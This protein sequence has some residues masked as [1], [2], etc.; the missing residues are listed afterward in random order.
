MKFLFVL[1]AGV[2]KS[3]ATTAI[4]LAKEA[5]AKGNEVT[6]FA[7]SSGVTNLASEK[8][9]SLAK[10]GVSITV[11]EHNRKEYVAPV[12][13]EGV[14]YGSQFDLAGYVADSDRALF[15]G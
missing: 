2:E 15:F 10:E 11:C 7:M 6:L 5:K 9:T 14:H 3:A 8:F 12:E 13:V 1:H 4:A